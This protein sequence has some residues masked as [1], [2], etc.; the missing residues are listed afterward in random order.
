MTEERII[1]ILKAEL[2]RQEADGLY[3]HISSIDD[4]VDV[5]GPMDLRDIARALQR[6]AVVRE[7]DDA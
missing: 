5:D 7:I 6:G 1:E 2:Q 3:L 4:T